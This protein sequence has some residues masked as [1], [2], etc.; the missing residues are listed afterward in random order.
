MLPEFCGQPAGAP[1]I[2]RLTGGSPLRCAAGLLLRRSLSRSA[3]LARAVKFHRVETDAHAV[4]FG[5]GGQHRCGGVDGDV[6][7]RLVV[8]IEDADGLLPCLALT[9]VD[10]TEIKHLPLHD[11]ASGAAVLGDAVIAV[12]FA[13][14]FAPVGFEKH[15]ADK[16]AAKSPKATLGVCTRGA[17]FST[18]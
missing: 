8:F 18:P 10:F 4:A 2:R 14:L 13:V 12:L 15:T 16:D 7:L 6:A 17:K 3:R 9:V 5:M 11:S 1:L